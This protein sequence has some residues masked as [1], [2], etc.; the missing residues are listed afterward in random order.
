MIIRRVSRRRPHAPHPQGRAGG[1]RLGGI[2]ALHLG[3]DRPERRTQRGTASAGASRFGTA[4]CVAAVRQ[5]GRV[6]QEVGGKGVGSTCA[7]RACA[8]APIRQRGL[9][10]RQDVDGRFARGNKR[11]AQTVWVVV[12]RRGSVRATSGGLARVFGGRRAAEI[13]RL[14]SSQTLDGSDSRPAH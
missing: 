8:D 13:R 6:Q 4:E 12:A 7:C 14:R 1:L 5:R 10:R 3:D 9:L 11:T 2:S